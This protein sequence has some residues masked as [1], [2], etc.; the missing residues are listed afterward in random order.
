MIYQDPTIR[1]GWSDN[2][3]CTAY[4]AHLGTASADKVVSVYISSEWPSSSGVLYVRDLDYT[5]AAAFKTAMSGVLLYYELATP[6]TIELGTITPPNIAPGDTLAMYA[7]LDPDWQI[8]YTQDPSIVVNTLQASIAP[9]EGATASTNYA[10]GAYLM[11]GNQLYRVTS[12]I[13]T[14][15]AIAPGT[16]CVSCTVMGEV[17]RLTA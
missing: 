13:A 12:A 16:N 5:D 2:L 8:R 17:I 7:S 10:V 11:H 1:N 3:L 6:Q 9:V 15:E 14:G 4:V